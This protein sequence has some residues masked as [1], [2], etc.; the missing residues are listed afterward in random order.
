LA[1]LTASLKADSSF[2]RVILALALGMEYAA[3]H[4]LKVKQCLSEND[5]FVLYVFKEKI[6]RNFN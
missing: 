4:S 5:C 6:S 3:I 2:N 1:I